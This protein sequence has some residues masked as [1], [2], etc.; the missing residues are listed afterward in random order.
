MAAVRAAVVCSSLGAEVG[1]EPV[2]L[3]VAPSPAFVA[4][5]GA[6]GVL[7]MDGGGDGITSG[8]RGFG[9]LSY[10]AAVSLGLTSAKLP[11]GGAGVSVATLAGVGEVGA[12]GGSTADLAAG[13]EALGALSLGGCTT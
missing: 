9:V 8:S 10:V 5:I 13:G 11:G 2:V 7:A 12:D 6:D 1:G 4:G 3:L